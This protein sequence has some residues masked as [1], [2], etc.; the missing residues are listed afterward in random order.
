MEFHG[1]I[2]KTLKDST[3]WWQTPSEAPPGAPNIVGIL[4]DD[5]GFSD[6]GCYG[7]EIQTPN[8]DALARNGLRF[9]N[10]HDRS[11]VYAGARGPAGPTGQ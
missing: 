10:L 5:L 11:H 7:S 4:L 3:P 6:L 8:I 2:G 1:T 9:A